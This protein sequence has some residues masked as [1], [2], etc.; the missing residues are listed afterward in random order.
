MFTD[1]FK[2]KTIKTW[3]GIL[4][5]FRTVIADGEERGK[6]MGLEKYEGDSK[7]ILGP[8]FHKSKKILLTAIPFLAI[9]PKEMTM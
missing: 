2:C 9:Y 1:L 8:S 7:G 4:V 3:A 5:N 6:E